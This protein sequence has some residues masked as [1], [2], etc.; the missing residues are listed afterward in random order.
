MD[1]FYREEHLVVRDD[2]VDR[3]LQV[4]DLVDTNRDLARERERRVRGVVDGLHLVRI[5]RPVEGAL[6]QVTERLGIGVAAPDYL[7]SITVGGFCPASEPEVP[8]V[9]SPPWPPPAADPTAG[10][11][12]RV[13]I[14]D[15][16]LD[17]TASTTYSWLQGLTG[18]VDTRIEIPRSGPHVLRPYSGHGTFIA[19]VLRRVAPMATVIVR[20]IFSPV[21][22]AFE[23]DLI[24]ELVD[25]IALDQPDVISLSAGTTV[26]NG[27]L[28]L[29]LQWFQN[30][31][32]P[33]VGGLALIAAAGN[34]AS[35][36]RFYPAA[37][38]PVFAVGALDAAQSQRAP[39]SNYGSWVDVLAPGTELV[40]AFPTGT[41]TTTETSSRGQVRNFTTGL[42]R[43]SGTSFATPILAGLTA[44]RMSAAQVDGQTA[45]Q[46][47]VS[48]APVVQG[49][50]RV[51][52]P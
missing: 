48:N 28:P 23:T 5:D 25:L 20:D 17:P 42:A 49:V 10:D 12:V 24:P 43:W 1:T 13:L 21:G 38:D 33:A 4:L 8:P 45:A 32:L 39:Y 29:V 50:G 51:L 27:T 40:N 35:C 37:F 30:D 47:L 46:Y 6:A 15:T 52:L 41:Y 36:E 26:L 2:Y 14:P 44:A 19:G 16:G 9:G 31:Y 18:D 3:V 7:L 11:G 22:T 34:N